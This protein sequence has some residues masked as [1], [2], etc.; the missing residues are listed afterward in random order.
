MGEDMKQRPITKLSEAML[1]ITAI[2]V[3]A[4][5]VHVTMDVALKYLI[6]T[7][8]QGTLEI[9]AYYYM[10]S[11]VVFPMAFVELTRQSIAVDLFYQ[12]V[13]RNLQILAMV[14]VLLLSALGYGGLGV[15]SWPEAMSSF[16]KREI[17]MGSINIYIWPTRFL[18]PLSLWVA[19]AVC[20]SLLYRLLTNEE[21]REQLIAIHQEDANTEAL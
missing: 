6:N 13:P 4:M 19:M 5:M 1:S 21:A 20:L 9:T 17:A 14:F 18:L 8:I 2:P 16:E 15:I 10:V 7:P 12:M 11:I 3:L